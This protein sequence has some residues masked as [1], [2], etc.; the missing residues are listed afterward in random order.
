LRVDGLHVEI[1]VR[2]V[3]SR[4]A[5]EIVQLYVEELEPRIARP[6]RELRA[7]APVVVEPGASA[8]VAF[9]LDERAFA[10]W[11][12]GW[13]AD[14]GTYRI[15]AGRSSRDIKVSEEVVLEHVGGVLSVRSM[16]AAETQREEQ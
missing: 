2:N 4:A 1:D 16:T 14:P 6:P 3:G 9:E 5:K 10:Y 15:L 12:S 8:T 13:R 11:D 7:F